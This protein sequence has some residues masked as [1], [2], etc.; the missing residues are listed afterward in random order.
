MHPNYC[1][2][3]LVLLETKIEYNKT[4]H[5][6]VLAFIIDKDVSESKK[7]KSGC[8]QFPVKGRRESEKEMQNDSTKSK[9]FMERVRQTERDRVI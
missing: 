9:D 5:Q 4:K 6:S 7:K 1:F 3:N 8:Q 2:P